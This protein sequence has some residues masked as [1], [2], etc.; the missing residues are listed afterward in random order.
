[1]TVPTVSDLTSDRAKPEAKHTGFATGFATVLIGSAT[2]S[3][4]GGM[5]L[6]KGFGVSVP[7]L[8]GFFLIIAFLFFVRPVAYQI[9][10]PWF[11]LAGQ[12]AL[13]LTAVQAALRAAT[14]AEDRGEAERLISL[15]D[16]IQ[17]PE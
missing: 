13:R 14:A 6:H 2:A 15:L 1:M 5:A 3:W 4:L 7:F 8:A 17:K 16:S 10:G 11:D 12:T 9:A